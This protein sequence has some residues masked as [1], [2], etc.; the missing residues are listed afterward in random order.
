MRVDIGMAWTDVDQ[1]FQGRLSWPA[2]GYIARFGLHGPTVATVQED[3]SPH[4]PTENLEVERKKS[5]QSVRST[6]PSVPSAT[7]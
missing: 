3:I 4:G 7:S 2:D 5:G 1:S 6:T